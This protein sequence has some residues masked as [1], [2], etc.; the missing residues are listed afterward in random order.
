MAE[1][2][3]MAV[4]VCLNADS[5]SSVVCSEGSFVIEFFSS[6]LRHATGSNGLPFGP[7]GNGGIGE[8]LTSSYTGKPFIQLVV[9]CDKHTIQKVRLCA[10]C[11][12]SEHRFEC[13]THYKS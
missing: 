4:V 13:R 2:T 10:N 9:L 8:V 5:S 3:V 1:A 12:E 11:A 7:L 6:K